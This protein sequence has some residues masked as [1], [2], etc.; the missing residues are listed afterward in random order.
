MTASST[1]LARTRQSWHRLA[2]HVLAA[3]Q[4]DAAGTIRLRPVPGGFGTV[5]GVDGRHLAVDGTELVVSDG[6][7]RRSAPLTTL[8][9]AAAFAGV[10]PGLRGSYPATTPGDLDSPLP[11]DGDAARMLAGWYALGDAALRR[12]AAELGAAGEPV[13]W[14]EHLD[15]AVTVD[16]TTYGCSPGDGYV[17][18]PYLYVSPAAG[19]PAGDPFWNQPFGAAVTAGEIPTVEDAVAFYRQGRT[20]QDRSTA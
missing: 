12:L 19:P 13:L 16:A 9:A 6:A 1:A 8:R 2:E 14:P 15:V 17:D 4:F 18:E 10:R 11:V 20:R 3:G 5:V 7:G